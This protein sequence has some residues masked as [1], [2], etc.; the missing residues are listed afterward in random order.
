MTMLTRAKVDDLHEEILDQD[1]E[2]PADTGD[3]ALSLRQLRG[4]E[5]ESDDALGGAADAEAAAIVPY[6]KGFCTKCGEAAFCHRAGNPGCGG[7]STD[8]GGTA[9]FVNRAWSKGCGKRLPLLT[10]PRSYVRDIDNLRKMYWGKNILTKML[11]SG[12]YAYKNTGYDG[13]VMQCI[14]KGNSVSVRWLHL[15]SFCEKGKVDNLPSRSGYCATMNSPADASKI[16]AAWA[17]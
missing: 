4:S 6:P 3:C 15:H 5:E 8:G 12:Y 16:A 9:T 2:C 1:G 17:R 14:H 11:T 10:I 7:K 13:P